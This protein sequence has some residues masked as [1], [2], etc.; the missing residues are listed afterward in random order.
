MHLENISNRRLPASRS[1]AP[2][3]QSQQRYLFTSNSFGGRVSFP[4][5]EHRAL[6]FDFETNEAEEREISEAI[7]REEALMAQE[8][9]QLHIKSEPD[10]TENDCTKSSPINVDRMV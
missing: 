7:A 9:Q 4:Q 8:E 10:E 6:S 2:Y 1:P 5:Q 3:L